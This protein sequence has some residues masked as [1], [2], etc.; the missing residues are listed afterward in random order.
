MFAKLRKPLRVV[1]ILLMAGIV[2]AGV[3]FVRPRLAHASCTGGC[4][5][6]IIFT[7]TSS[8]TNGDIATIDNSEINGQPNLV[9]QVVQVWPNNYDPHPLGIW[10]DAWIGKWTI[11]NEDQQNIPIGTTFNVQYLPYDDSAPEYYHYTQVTA[12]QNVQGDSVLISDPISNGNP[13]AVIF[14]TQDLYTTQQYPGVYNPHIIG[15]WYTGGKRAVYNEDLAQMPQGAI[16]NLTIEANA[17][18]PEN[19]PTLLQTATAANTN[20]YFT[21]INDP[22]FNGQPNLHVL[23]VHV[24]NPNGQCPCTTFDHQIGVWYDASVGEWAVYAVDF[25]PI[26]A[27]TA[28]FVEQT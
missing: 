18:Q 24:Y 6:S 9:L 7:T 26:P 5:L 19:Y 10:Y 3:A 23:A 16:F 11:F 8:N 28:F 22:R 2:A 15:V 14:A 25:A 21:H 13:N 4:P 27:G 12:N 1:S 20:G 17:S